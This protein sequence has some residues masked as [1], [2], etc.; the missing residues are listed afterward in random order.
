MWPFKCGPQHSREM[1]IAW[2]AFRGKQN[3]L[4]SFDHR[5][6]AAI[7]HLA[8]SENSPALGMQPEGPTLAGRIKAG[9]IAIDEARRIAQQIADALEYAREHGIIDRDL[10]PANLKVASKMASKALAFDLAKETD[11]P[12]PGQSTR[13]RKERMDERASSL[14]R[15]RFAGRCRS[16]GPGSCSRLL[17]LGP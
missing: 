3:V 12:A 13:T 5:N 14:S 9:P 6:V 16:G 2:R 10:M 7:H 17:R 15:I 8:D 1:P 11:V 4:A